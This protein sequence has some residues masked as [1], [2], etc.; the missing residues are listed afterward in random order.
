[1]MWFKDCARPHLG[2]Y[3]GVDGKIEGNIFS[4]IN[5]APAKFQNVKFEKI[6]EPPYALVRTL[7]SIQKGEEL[8]IDYGP[9]YIY[10]FM[11]DK[12]IQNFFNPPK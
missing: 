8:Y 10:D 7:R 9:D 2:K 4:R 6:C 5:Y 12:E 3:V 1:V 11:E